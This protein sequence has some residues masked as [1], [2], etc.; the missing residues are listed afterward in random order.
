MYFRDDSASWADRANEPE[1][2]SCDATFFHVRGDSTGPFS[3]ARSTPTRGR[4]RGSDTE[5]WRLKVTATEIGVSLR[6]ATA[7]PAGGQD[8][9]APF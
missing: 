5:R 6:H 9:E 8:E 2:L 3:S 7:K 1:R 4:L